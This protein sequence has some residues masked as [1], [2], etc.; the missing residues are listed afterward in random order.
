LA[1]FQRSFCFQPPDGAV[2]L[3]GGPGSCGET[4]PPARRLMGDSTG[5]VQGASGSSGGLLRRGH[6]D[7][8]YLK[9]MIVGAVLVGSPVPTDLKHWACKDLFANAGSRRIE[10]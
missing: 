5:A 1:E 4:R 3:G 8:R 2:R 9:K 7:L 6:A 10:A